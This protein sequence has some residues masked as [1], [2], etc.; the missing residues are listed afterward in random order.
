MAKFTPSPAVASISG[1]LGAHT[2]R[3]TRN[4]PVLARR[5][6]RRRHK[7][8]PQHQADAEWAYLSKAW[9]ELTFEQHLAWR[10]LARVLAR[11]NRF[12]VHRPMTAFQTFMSHNRPTL[13]AGL[14]LIPNPPQ[15]QPLKPPISVTLAFQNPATYQ[16]GIFNDQPI[17]EFWAIVHASRPF[18]LDHSADYANSH[19]IPHWHFRFWRLIYMVE[20][21]DGPDS[22]LFLDEWTAI[23]GRCQD[24]EEVALRVSLWNPDSFRSTAFVGTDIVSPPP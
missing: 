15:R 4:G 17:P 10:A 13:F 7:S 5:G 19:R 21:F 18:R 11:P 16:A 1:S 14:P 20:L 24:L 22:L 2:F 23:L 12:A 8:Q 3:L 9:H 6:L